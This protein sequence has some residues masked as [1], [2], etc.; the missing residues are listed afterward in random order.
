MVT[1][2]E[3]GY[4]KAGAY[5][6]RIENQVEVVDDGDGFLSFRS[7]TLVPIDM[8]LAEVGL[9]TQAERQWIDDYHRRVVREVDDLLDSETLA[10][11]AE[12]TAPIAG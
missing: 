9:L 10:W 4:Y 12:R 7:L 11:L 2:I 5:G 6:I 8:R 1:T 3:P